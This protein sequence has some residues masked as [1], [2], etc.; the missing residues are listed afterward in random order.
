MSTGNEVTPREAANTA[1]ALDDAIR[2][3]IFDVLRKEPYMVAE[4]VLGAMR[5][6]PQFSRDML[7]DAIRN[8]SYNSDLNY[9]LD[10]VVKQVLQNI[11]NRA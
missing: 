1:L 3:R 7:A 5:M 6:Y 10:V 4:L 2:D 11:L 8:H 9:Q